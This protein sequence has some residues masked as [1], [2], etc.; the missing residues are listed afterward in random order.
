M[1]QVEVYRTIVF[2][3]PQRALSLFEAL[4]ADNWTYF[5]TKLHNGCLVPD[6]IPSRLPR[7]LPNRL[8]ELAL[9]ALLVSDSVYRRSIQ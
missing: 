4:I 2:D 9:I 6:A 8:R 5:F 7:A 3:A 1:R